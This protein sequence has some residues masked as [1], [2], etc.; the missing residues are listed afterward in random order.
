MGAP[1]GPYGAHG[2]PMGPH[3]GPWGPMGPKIARVPW[4][5]VAITVVWGC[6]VLLFD[7]G[8]QSFAQS[9]AVADQTRQAYAGAQKCEAMRRN[10]KEASRPSQS[11]IPTSVIGPIGPPRSYTE[12]RGIPSIFRDFPDSLDL[13]IFKGFWSPGGIPEAS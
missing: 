8:K 2:A 13:W 9:H 11:R 10:S 5:R 12:Y 3:G 1:W 6:T 7:L 4:P